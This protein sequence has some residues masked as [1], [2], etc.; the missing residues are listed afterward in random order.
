MMQTTVLGRTGLTV[1][2]AGFGCGGH[3][4]AGQT[5]GLTEDQSAD[6]IRAAFDLGV[7]L[8]DTAQTYGTEP[9]V[10][11]AIAGRR[12]KV[13]VCTK[14]RINR[15][16]TDFNSNDLVGG[17]DIRR[18]VEASLGKLRTDHVDVL[19]LHGV[20]PNQYDHAVSHILPELRAMQAEGKIRFVGVTE[21]FGTDREHVM[22]SRALDDGNWD[23][24]MVGCNFV[25]HSIGRAVLPKAIEKNVGTLCM[26]AVRGAIADPRKLSVLI[27]QLVKTGEL[28]ADAAQ[29][30]EALD[31]PRKYGS[32]IEAAYRFCRHMPGLTVTL[33]GTSKLDHLKAN[34]A[35]L[36]KPPLAD[37][38]IKAL[39]AIFGR[40]VSAN[41]DP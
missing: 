20:R 37:E 15:P 33:F 39:K 34:I 21:G 23:V 3:S 31:L 28:D 40:V 32:M 12:D 4:R 35:T 22:L 24:L 25:N 18:N 36:N 7:N 8:V 27:A 17:A 19:Q 16:G 38:D 1:S 11:K 30:L 26:Y 29:R 41:A 9:V 6:L 5:A 14:T 10:G 13:V 2:V